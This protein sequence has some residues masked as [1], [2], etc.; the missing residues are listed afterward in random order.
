[1]KLDLRCQAEDFAR[2]RAGEYKAVVVEGKRSIYQGTSSINLRDILVVADGNGSSRVLFEVEKVIAYW[3]AATLDTALQDVKTRLGPESLYLA[4]NE[5]NGF[6]PMLYD[7]IHALIIKPHTRR[8]GE[9]GKY[10]GRAGR[11]DS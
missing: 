1:M 9:G 7:G 8:T 3:G 10:E 5:R 6:L 4:P 11:T 2:F